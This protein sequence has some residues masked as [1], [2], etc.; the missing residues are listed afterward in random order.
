MPI[1]GYTDLLL[2]GSLGMLTDGQYEGVE[3]INRSAQRLEALINQ[4]IQFA[5]SVKGKR[6]ANPTILH[7]PDLVEPVWD[8]FQ[9]KADAAGVRRVREVPASLP[10]ARADAEKI[11]WVLYPLLDNAIKFTPAGR[12][13][14]LAAQ[15]GTDLMRLSVRDTGIGIRPEKLGLIFEPFSQAADGSGQWVDGSGRG[16]ALVKRIVEAHDARVQVE[17]RLGQGS[18]FAFELPLVH[19]PAE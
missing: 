7:V 10:L 2:N 9:P 15:V 16:L 4:L 19:P 12:R 5:S 1:K 8:Y 17:S 6:M 14:I 11:Y 3:I 18:L 13:A